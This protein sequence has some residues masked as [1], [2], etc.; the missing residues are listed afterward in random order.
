MLVKLCDFL[1]RE[2]DPKTLRCPGC[3]GNR[4]EVITAIYRSKR[5]VVRLKC[6][7]ESCARKGILDVMHGF[8]SKR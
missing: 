7:K 1:I 2:G 8:V 6:L 5:C 4:F 3:R